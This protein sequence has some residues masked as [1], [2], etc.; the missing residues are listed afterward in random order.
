[1]SRPSCGAEKVS[2][3]EIERDSALAGVARPA[4]TPNSLLGD[5]YFLSF[6][7]WGTQN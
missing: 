5:V 3:E 1:M 6:L 7:L 4:S 2:R